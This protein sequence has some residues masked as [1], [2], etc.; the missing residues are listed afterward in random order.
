MYYY[1]S[2]IPITRQDRK[3]NCIH[4]NNRLHYDR[5][6]QVDDWVANGGKIKHVGVVT[7]EVSKVVM[8]DPA[9]KKPPRRGEK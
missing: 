2:Q 1:L 6:K 3:M 7:R 8:S 9:K 5:L 4:E